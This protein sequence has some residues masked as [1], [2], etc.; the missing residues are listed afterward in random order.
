MDIRN[1]FEKIVVFFTSHAQKNFIAGLFLA[2]VALGFCAHM[3]FKNNE[4]S[5]I[6]HLPEQVQDAF[7][8]F[9]IR[10]TQ[11]EGKLH[12]EMGKIEEQI[13]LTEAK[14]LEAEEKL[15]SAEGQ[16]STAGSK[17]QY[18]EN[19]IRDIEAKVQSP[20]NAQVAVQRGG[21][22]AQVDEEIRKEVKRQIKAMEQG[23]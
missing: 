10:L 3:Y 15:R 16:I 2:T 9:E 23:E 6:A 13:K 7:K 1:I 11:T 17:L 18:T 4:V 8:S 22:L 5:E 14:L 21:E 20:M 12:Q 19:K